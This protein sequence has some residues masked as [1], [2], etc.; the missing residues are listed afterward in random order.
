[1]GGFSGSNWDSCPDLLTKDYHI[2]P[3]AMVTCQ[4]NAAATPLSGTPCSGQVLAKKIDSGI[5]WAHPDYEC[6]SAFSGYDL[7]LRTIYNGLTSVVL[8]SA[9]RRTAKHAIK[10]LHGGSTCKYKR[11][12]EGQCHQGASA[13]VAPVPTNMSNASDRTADAFAP[14]EPTGQSA[15]KLRAEAAKADEELMK[16]LKSNP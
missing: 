14:K 7:G 9:S 15:S 16:K 8:I 12:I 13:W 11:T 10:C 1:M 3:D 4:P 5:A 2:R 6:N